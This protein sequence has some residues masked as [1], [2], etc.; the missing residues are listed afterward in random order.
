M[1]IIY[2]ITIATVLISTFTISNGLAQ[3]PEQSSPFHEGAKALQFQISENFNLE[4]FSGTLFAYKRYLS[5]DRANK[6]GLSLNSQYITSDFPDNE[7]DREDSLTDL[8]L[9]V[10][11]TRMHYTNPDSEIKFYYGYGPGINFGYDRTVIDETNSKLTNQSTLYGIS[12]IGYAG[13]ELFFHSSMS[14]H[15]EYQS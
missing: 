6:I 2:K 15:A 3:E 8:N 13:V 5:E 11:Y 7:N 4:S 1:D 12:G 14:L 9:G 10:E